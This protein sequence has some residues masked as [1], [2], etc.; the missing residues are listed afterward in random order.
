MKLPEPLKGYNVSSVDNV[1]VEVDVPFDPFTHKSER[2]ELS[3]PAGVFTFNL[4]SY[5][6]RFS[7]KNERRKQIKMGESKERATF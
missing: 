3:P 1:S 5:R 4:Y 2:T 7:E 6:R